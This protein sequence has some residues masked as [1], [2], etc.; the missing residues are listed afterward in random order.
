MNRKRIGIAVQITLLVVILSV[1]C[2]TLATSLSV[3]QLKKSYINAKIHGITDVAAGILDSYKTRVERGEFTTAEAQRRALANLGAMRFD[4]GN[5]LQV[6]D[7]ASMKILESPI[8][9]VG[10]DI[11][12]ISDPKG[13]Y[14]FKD[15][16]EGAVA[17]KNDTAEATYLGRM[18]GLDH[19]VPKIGASRE[20]KAWDWVIAASI[21]EKDLITALWGELKITL[22][23]SIIVVILAIICVQL[24]YVRRL[25]K[26]L[27][28]IT[29]GL[30]DSTISV[31]GSA[32]SL[33]DS[34]QKLAEGTNQQAASVQEIVA[35]IE[36]SASM[37]KKT[38][39]SSSYALKLA[40]ESKE[41]ASQGY[42]EMN[43]LMISMGKIDN[44]TK[45]I[46]K[47][48]KII[49]EIALQTNILSLNAAVEAQRAG[50]AGKGFAVVAE[51]VRNLAQRSTE[52]V[53]DTTELIENNAAT[54]REAAKLAGQV[55]ESIKKIE[56]GTGQVN[57]L[58]N[59]VAAATRE[60][61]IGIEQIHS[62][63]SQVEHVLQTNARTAGDTSD[64]SQHLTEQTH[65]LNSLSEKLVSFVKG[66]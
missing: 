64:D 3:Y 16:V 8:F 45:E 62:A 54:Y 60:Q 7:V 37:I 58:I 24:L 15:L 25:T 27:T 6:F 5:F 12:T 53:K 44:A 26:T 18:P 28:E 13:K 20:Y 63:I 46:S 4:G 21:T 1:V 43:E 55:H 19:L 47:I 23:A 35:T 65:V 17:S 11:N 36:E 49:D 56:R 59:E 48:I 61:K 10:S 50:D 2:I 57:E 14:Y 66:S 9:P 39:E 29:G 30:E 34:S 31:S 51:E 32:T 40:Q 33:E 52:S 41:Q 22:L 42:K 38:D